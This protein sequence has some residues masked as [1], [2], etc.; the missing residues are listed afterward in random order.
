MKR[1]ITVSVAFPQTFQIE[2][3][4]GSLGEFPSFAG[5]EEI[6]RKIKDHA[7]YLMETSQSEPMIV[8]SPDF[9]ELED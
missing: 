7:G 6:K 8:S 5:L 1:T 4:D 9:P 2:I 3:E